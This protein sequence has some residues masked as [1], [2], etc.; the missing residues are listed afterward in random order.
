MKWGVESGYFLTRGVGAGLMIVSNFKKQMVFSREKTNR[1]LLLPLLIAGSISFFIFYVKLSVRAASYEA[2]VT[3]FTVSSSSV[4]AAGVTYTLK[5][6]F[7]QQFVG[8][9]SAGGEF[10]LNRIPTKEGGDTTSN[11]ASATG[12]IVSFQYENPADT[13]NNITYGSFTATIS[14]QGLLIY[15]I[16]GIQ[17]NI[18][19][20]ATVK[21]VVNSV[22]N[23]SKAGAYAF[24]VELQDQ[25]GDQFT[26]LPI[27]NPSRTV[28]A[29]IG[30]Y[31][32]KAK[33]TAPDGTTAMPGLDIYVDSAD[34]SFNA[35]LETDYQGFV[36]LYSDGFNGIDSCPS[37]TDQKVY[38]QVNIDPSY[39]NPNHYI[40]PAVTVATLPDDKD[41]YVTT[42]IKLVQATKTITGTV[43]YSDGSGTVSGAQ[44]NAFQKNGGSFSQ[45]TTNS[46]GVYTILVG[47]GE[48]EV[49]PQSD[50]SSDWAYGSPPERVS[51]QED[52]STESET[53]N[54]SVDKATA[55]VA[56][57]VLK[58]D[59][60]P[61]SQSD[62]L[63]IGLFNME[64]KGGGG[65]IGDNGAFQINVPAGTYMLEVWAPP[66]SSWGSPSLSPITVKDNQTLNVG[67]ITLV[68]KDATIT[69]S[70]KVSGTNAA[71][72]DVTVNAFKRDGGGFSMGTTGTDGS[73]SLKV[74]SGNWMVMPIFGPTDSYALTDPPQEIT[75]SSGGTASVSFSV[76]SATATVNGT[77]VDSSGN[78]VS[79][80]GYAFAET[81][82]GDMFGP[83]GMG[84]P[85]ERGS[86]S[87]KVPAG[88]YTINV[89]LA[90]GSSYSAGDGVDVT[91]ADGATENI[92]IVLRENDATITGSILDE[93]GNAISPSDLFVFAISEAGGH[94]VFQEG[95]V[96]GSSYTINVAA[97]EWMLGY[98]VDPSSGYMSAPPDPSLRFT[99]SAGGTKTKNIVLQAANST[100]SGKVTKPDGSAAVGVFVSADNRETESGELFNG[101]PT[102]SNGDYT[103]NISSGTYK[104]RANVAPGSGYLSPAEK[105]VTVAE[106]GT[107]TVNFV[108]RQSNATISGNVTLNGTGKPSFV[109]AWSDD[110]GFTQTIANSSGSYSLSASQGTTW[111]VG[112]RYE[113]G[114]NAYEATE[115][116]VNLTG[117]SATANLS[118][119]ALDYSLPQAYSVTFDAT[120]PKII[121]LTDGTEINIP[122]NALATS[123]NVTLSVSPKAS[124]P[125]KKGDRPIWY[126]YE[127]SAINNSGQAITQFN[128]SITITFPYTDAQLTKLGI[129]ANDLIPSYWDSTSGTWRKVDNVTVDTTAKTVTITTNHFTDFA[130][131][132]NYTVSTSTTTTTTSSSGSVAGTTSSGGVSKPMAA[133]DTGSIVEGY[134]NRV[135]LMIPSGALKWDADFEMS[136]LKSGFQKPTPPLWIASGPYKVVMKSWWNGA[137]FN[138]LNQPITLIIRYDPYALGLIPEESLRLN[139]YDE[140]RKRWRPISSLLITDRHEVAAVVDRIHGIYALVGGYGYQGSPSYVEKTVTATSDSKDIGLTEKVLPKEKVKE[141]ESTA[142]KSKSQSVSQAGERQA[143]S[144]TQRVSWWQRLWNK[145]T[146][147]LPF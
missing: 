76:Q 116:A 81:S 53:V 23:P 82:G 57:T 111:H 58:P 67:N 139:Y 54:F 103:I 25:N 136:K 47:G 55:T 63:G 127:F 19:A 112:A 80:Y 97:G 77:L 29:D 142:E 34:H 59:G 133:K 132:A 30:S 100:I 2:T 36:S 120:K 105:T 83:G 17:T 11:M 13:W 32:L 96:S 39:S 140:A 129:T 145:I 64:G 126:G 1:W 87:F 5:F 33:V 65:Q 119:S 115:V 98:F 75:V 20:D 9:S 128:S 41:T 60:T 26:S 69:G 121:T 8:G 141:K 50:S 46:S 44:V 15:T 89:G 143:V 35:F 24:S 118:L 125:T 147:I 117:S 4:S 85:I 45:A 7:N 49:M 99:V 95:V 79:T 38:L 16:S 122:A 6:K 74:T 108:L 101:S 72:A 104:L 144:Q 18:P 113:I 90:P 61:V 68:N 28:R 109:Y 84:G 42:P 31:C 12:S 86:F 93:N 135:V 107:Q 43:S 94:K 40:P 48:W 78:L 21:L 22:T 110:G 131:T 71:V 92:S 146:S 130:L 137:K 10:D 52:N 66:E 73:F 134:F 114:T 14:D 51:F 123:G 27:T 91:V 56:G 88:S 70:V 102:D 37:G 124:L 3:D 138:Q 62:G 106:N